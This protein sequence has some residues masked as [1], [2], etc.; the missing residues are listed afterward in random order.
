MRAT[1]TA[2]IKECFELPE[3]IK[4]MD[5]EGI[6][7]LK[8]GYR[9]SLKDPNG[10]IGRATISF[11]D[12]DY[13]K[14]KRWL[15]HSFNDEPSVTFTNDKGEVMQ[16][17]H[18]MGMTHRDEGPA[19][20]RSFSHSMSDTY[21]ECYYKHGKIHRDNGPAWTNGFSG[22][23]SYFKDGKLHNDHGPAVINN[24]MGSETWYKDGAKHRIAGPAYVMRDLKGNVTFEEWYLFGLLHRE[25]GAARITYED[26]G[27]VVEVYFMFN[28]RIEENEFRRYVERR[29][30]AYINDVLL[31]QDKKKLDD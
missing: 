15:L 26:N 8:D 14:N 24:L 18:W 19:W 10:G 17:W 11:S 25:D 22:I 28:A 16:W 29:A 7:T 21:E 5:I 9:F 4:M 2:T 20:I 31:N 12:S 6:E 30:D 3:W 13:I 23:E 27:N 1:Y